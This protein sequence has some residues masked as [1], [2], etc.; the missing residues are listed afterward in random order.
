MKKEF[1]NNTNTCTVFSVTQEFERHVED[2][3]QHDAGWQV[4]ED[5]GRPEKIE[6]M[7]FEVK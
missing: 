1:I 3:T 7:L 4:S 6:N 2:I 5:P